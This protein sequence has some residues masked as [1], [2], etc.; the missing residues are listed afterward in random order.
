MLLLSQEPGFSV[1]AEPVEPALVQC[2]SS[3]ATKTM[4]HMT[5]KQLSIKLLEKKTYSIHTHEE[6]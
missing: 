5:N 4:N 3:T 6:S 2:V 1:L